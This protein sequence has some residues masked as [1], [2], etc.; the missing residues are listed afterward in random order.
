MPYRL[1]GNY[2][3]ICNC[4]LWCAC[5]V[6]GAPTGEDDQCHGFAVYQIRRGN[7]D[8]TILSGVLFALSYF[9]PS[10]P[11]AGDWK[12]GVTVDEHASDAQIDALGRIL[13]GQEGGP[14]ADLAPLIG[15]FTGVEVGQISAY[16]LDSPCGSV[17]GIGDFDGE[18]VLEADGSA[19]AVTNTL[20]GF[21]PTY[22]VGRPTSRRFT[23][24][25]STFDARY[26]ETAEYEYSS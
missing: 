4:A 22:R 20:F 26:A 21:A 10:N 11:A 24:F 3:T 16:G 8:E 12:F 25:G 14:F 2:V 23:V 13:S 1:K 17:S 5:S 19:T 6:D 7:L 9:F 18:Y 15:E